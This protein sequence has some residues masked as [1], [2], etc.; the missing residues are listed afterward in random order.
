MLSAPLRPPLRPFLVV[1][2]H[3]P[4][5]VHV[6]HDGHMVVGQPLRRPEGTRPRGVGQ[7]L[8]GPSLPRVALRQ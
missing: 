1:G 3:L 2:I 6:G 5:R 4:D 7:D 8:E